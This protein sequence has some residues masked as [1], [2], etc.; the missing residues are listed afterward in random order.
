MK[1]LLILAMTAIAFMACNQNSPSINNGDK[2]A[3][4]AVASGSLDL[5]GKSKQQVDQTLKGIGFAQVEHK[6]QSLVTTRRTK[7]AISDASSLTEINYAYNIPAEYIYASGDNKEAA[8]YVDK[9]LKEGRSYVVVSNYF[10]QDKLVAIFTSIVSGKANKVNTLYTN[11]SDK[12]YAALQ[13]LCPEF[14]WQGGTRIKSEEKLYEDHKSFSAA[15]ATAEEVEVNEFYD[16][17][18][19][20]REILIEAFWAHHSEE[21]MEKD[22]VLPMIWGAIT[23]YDAQY[24]SSL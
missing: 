5:M 20:S 19:D 12:I 1:K 7:K 22:Y 15:I 24:E 21:Q 9:L 2:K 4:A 6:D 8:E 14:D 23:T 18:I 11:E 10:D 13:K 17:E 3:F 16:F